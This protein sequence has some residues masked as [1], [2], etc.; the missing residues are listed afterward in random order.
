MTLRRA[1][2]FVIASTPFV[3][4]GNRDL[5]NRSGERSFF[6]LV[7]K[8]TDNASNKYVAHNQH[9]HG[10]GARDPPPKM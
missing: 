3:T 2:P 9:D 8:D 1:D 6:L 4:A 10:Q 5:K 7:T